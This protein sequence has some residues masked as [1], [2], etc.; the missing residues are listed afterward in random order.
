MRRH[1]HEHL[2]NGNGGGGGG[3]AALRTSSTMRTAQWQAPERS[4]GYEQYYRH[5]ERD[6]EQEESVFVESFNSASDP[7][8]FLRLVR[9]PFQAHDKAERLLV[10]LRVECG[11]SVEVGTAKPQ[12][13]GKT[14]HYTQKV[15]RMASRKRSL[16]FIYFDGE[17]PRSLTLSETR[18]LTEA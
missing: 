15:R 5:G 17:S 16:R 7:V 6:L 11:T 10:L 9:I 13:P 14:M 8:S 1:D 4:N 2:H 12:L 3:R 18:E